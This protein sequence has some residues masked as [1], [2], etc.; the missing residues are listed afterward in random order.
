MIFNYSFLFL[1][2]L[3]ILTNINIS[4]AECGC[5]SRCSVYSL[6]KH[7][8]RCCTSFVKRETMKLKGYN[9]KDVNLKD[10]QF[11]QNMIRKNREHKSYKYFSDDDEIIESKS[12]SSSEDLL[13]QIISEVSEQINHKD[14]FF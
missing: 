11:N 5:G 9:I 13:I 10:H 1:I 14:K 3:F 4:Q 8:V 2:L 12:M 6:P 7:C